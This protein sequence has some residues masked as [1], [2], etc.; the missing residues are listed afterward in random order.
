MKQAFVE[1]VGPCN[2]RQYTDRNGQPQTF[3]ER[4]VKLTDGLNSVN[5]LLT[6]DRARRAPNYAVGDYVRVELSA[7]ARE[8]ETQAGEKRYDTIVYVDRIAPIW[9]SK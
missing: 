9:K 1:M 8:W 4:V 6:G 3:A 5:A 7:Q 2:E